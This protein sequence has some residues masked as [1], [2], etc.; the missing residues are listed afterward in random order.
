MARSKVNNLVLISFLF[1]PVIFGCAMP[2]RVLWLIRQGEK[3]VEDEPRLVEMTAR[4]NIVGPNEGGE[5]SYELTSSEITLHW[6]V[7]ERKGETL[8][9]VWGEGSSVFYS[10]VGCPDDQPNTITN[11][12]TFSGTVSSDGITYS[13][14][15]NFK[16]SDLCGLTMSAYPAGWQAIRVGDYIEGEIDRQGAFS[17]RVQ[18]PP[19]D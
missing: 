14:V 19:S 9:K 16:S 13:G 18:P 12:L 5:F 6:N 8:S 3:A 2:A 17:L 7:D 1:L 15:V 4:G 11:Q 10:S